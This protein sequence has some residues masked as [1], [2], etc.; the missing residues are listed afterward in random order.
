M[1]KVASV[2]P[3]SLART[4]A[5][6]HA[7]THTYARTVRHTHTHTTRHTCT[8]VCARTYIQHR[9]HTLSH[10][11]THTHT[12]SLS[13]SLSLLLLHAADAQKE[14]KLVVI[15]STYTDVIVLGIF[16]S[17]QIANL[18]IAA[19]TK[20]NS[21]LIDVKSIRQQ[22]GETLS[23]TLPGVHAVSGCDFTSSF[24][25]KG[26]RTWFTRMKGYRQLLDVLGSF[27]TSFQFDEE[28]VKGIERAVCSVYGCCGNS[29]NEARFFLFSTSGHVGRQLPPTLDALTQHTKRAWYQTAIWKSA[30]VGRMA[31]PSPEGYGWTLEE[32]ELKIVWM[33]Q[34]QSSDS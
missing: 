33:L 26:K 19:G 17:N 28:S 20:Q 2:E 32:G 21:R 30:L 3:G 1:L 9:T 7:H 34:L 13:L 31:T 14:C 22:L 18:V 15:K 24:A 6:T 4:H 12:L 11:H 5:H 16:F 29:V 8:H 27:G 23:D 25:G 10:T